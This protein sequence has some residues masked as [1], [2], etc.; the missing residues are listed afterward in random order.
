[1]QGDYTSSG[2]KPRKLTVNS[3]SYHAS[4]QRQADMMQGYNCAIDA[5]S[6][7]IEGAMPSKNE[8]RECLNELI[9]EEGL[10]ITCTMR[11]PEDAESMFVD[12]IHALITRK[13][14]GK[15]C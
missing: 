7:W 3:P 15:V 14:T 11:C 5:M 8:L 2:E 6:A 13:L 10:G 12:K 9:I 1:M 4:P